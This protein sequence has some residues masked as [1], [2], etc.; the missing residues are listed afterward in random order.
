MGLQVG[1]DAMAADIRGLRIGLR[2]LAGC[3]AVE[4]SAHV[5]PRAVQFS[6]P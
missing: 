4:P 3:L 1:L 6:M 5:Y 2:E